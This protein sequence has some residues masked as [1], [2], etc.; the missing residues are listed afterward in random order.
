[1]C[2]SR[3]IYCIVFNFRKALLF[4]E[5]PAA[6][7]VPP[8]FADF[9]F[10]FFLYRGQP[11]PAAAV[12]LLLLLAALWLVQWKLAGCQPQLGGGKE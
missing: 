4:A 9:F 5:A 3:V 7:S 1:M 11:S 6:P 12:A 10:F 2:H 8:A